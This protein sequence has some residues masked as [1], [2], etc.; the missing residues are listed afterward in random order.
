M[1]LPL[2]YSISVSPRYMYHGASVTPVVLTPPPSFPLQYS[3]SIVYNVPKRP[4]GRSEVQIFVNG[5]LKKIAVMRTP[6]FSD[7]SPDLM[8][9]YS[10]NPAS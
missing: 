4:W 9:A 1:P 2:W 8:L 5:G 6:N 3:I 7:V 10:S